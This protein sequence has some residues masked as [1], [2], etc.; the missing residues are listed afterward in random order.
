[1]AASA[2]RPAVLVHLTALVLAAHHSPGAGRTS[3]EA[4]HPPR[5]C[6][7]DRNTLTATLGHLVAVNAVG[8]WTF[9]SIADDVTWD[10]PRT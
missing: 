4:D 9:E 6:G 10:P 8:A 2:A 5:A 1:M 7:L 3:M